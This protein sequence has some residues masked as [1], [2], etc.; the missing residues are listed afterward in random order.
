MKVKKVF[1]DT[2]IWL[3]FLVRDQERQYAEVV[4][5]I[6]MIENGALLPYTSTIV[7]L[8][9]FFVLTK[10]YDIPPNQVQGD[11]ENLLKLRN[12]TL[13]EKTQFRRALLLHQQSKVKLANCL[14]A[15]Q[16]P[17]GVVL[18]SFDKEFQKIPH[19]DWRLP[20]QIL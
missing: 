3:R 6:Q 12:L 16:L 13:I 18:C 11:I 14:I 5:L 20:A 9:L 19:L 1:L 7:F 15:T 4:A 10:L 8:E 17:P 2:N